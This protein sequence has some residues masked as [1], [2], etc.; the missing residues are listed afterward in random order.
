MSHR[1]CKETV[2]SERIDRIKSLLSAGHRT[3]TERVAVKFV[4][5]RKAVKLLQTYLYESSEFRRAYVRP[6]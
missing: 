6:A 1:R 3:D 5:R 4:R 2:S